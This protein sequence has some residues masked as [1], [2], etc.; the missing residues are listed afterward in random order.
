MLRILVVLYNKKAFDSETILSIKN[1]ISEIAIEVQLLLWNNSS[2]KI[3][4]VEL[5]FLS[6]FVPHKIYGNDGCN[7]SLS[8]I[9]TRIYQDCDDDDILLIFDHD[10]IIPEGYFSELLIA[11]SEN[12]DI[13]LFLPI[14]KHHN[15]II[16]PSKN[17]GVKG[18]YWKRPNLGILPA[19]HITAINSGM[20][21]RCQYLK[22]K[23]VG[24]NLE[25]KFYETD[26]DFMYKYCRE[27][28]EL[29][30]L[31]SQMNH[32]LGFYDDSVNSKLN[33]FKAMKFGRLTHMKTRGMLLYLLAQLQYFYFA[34]KCTVKY[35]DLRFLWC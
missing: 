21:I 33:R 4:N 10:T 5:D 16:S 30:V 22:H 24:Y 34:I 12:P 14:V 28:R 8:E 3:T 31:S 27:N 19:K 7:T 35:H 29:F 13:N 17:Y 6:S 32:S 20:A 2:I 15:L 9:Y 26:N 11:I 23:F 1:Y 25:L 18:I